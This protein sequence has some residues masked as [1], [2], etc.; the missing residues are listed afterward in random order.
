MIGEGLRLMV[1]GMSGIFIVTG[2]VYGFMKIL[3]KLDKNNK[4]A[5]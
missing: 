3:G 4:E 5:N 2:I 1:F